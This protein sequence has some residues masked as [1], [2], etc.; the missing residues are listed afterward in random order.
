[1]KIKYWY[2]LLKRIRRGRAVLLAA[3]VTLSIIA[4][5]CATPPNPTASNSTGNPD[6]GPQPEMPAIAATQARS[7][8]TETRTPPP[9]D[10]SISL[11]VSS[12]R[13]VTVVPYLATGYRYL[14]V[15]T[16]QA[17]AGFEQPNFD[18]SAF[19]VGDAAFGSSGDCPIAS[20]VI[21]SWPIRTDI[22]L[23]KKFTLPSGATGLK[24]AVAIDNDIQVFVN[25]V[26]ISGGL[27]I[28][29][30]C[31][32]N[33]SF[34]FSAPDSVLN[35][36]ENLVAVLGRDRGIES[37]L[38]IQV[39]AVIPV[40]TITTT[41]DPSSGEI[42]V[43]LNDSATLSDG[44][45]PT[46]TITFNLYRPSD[47]TCSGTPAF[48]N[49]VPVNGNGTYPTS[50]G[51]L[52]NAVGIWH[53]TATYSGDNNNDPASSLCADEPVT[54]NPATPFITT[55]PDPSSGMI[56]EI[57][58]DSATL[59]DGFNPTGDITFN[60]YAPSDPTCSG[61]PVFT[62]VVPVNGNGTY[63]T[64][65]GF[66]SNAVGVWQWTADYSGDSNNDPASS[67]CADEP[68][69][70]KKAIP[71]IA[72]T[73]DPSSG[74][75]GVTLNDSADLSR[76]F[77]PTGTITFNLYPPNDPTCSGV[78][79]FTDVVP[80]DGEGTYPTSSGFVS[81][82]VGVWHWT[83]TYSGDS[84]NDA[85]SSDCGDEPVTISPGPPIKVTG[86]GQ[87][88]VPEPT[89]NGQAT[90]GFNAQQNEAGSTAATGHFNYVNHDTGLHVNGPVNEIQVIA[91]YPDGSPKT[92]QFSGTCDGN[93]PACTFIV[94]VEDH[95]EPG[96][97]DEFG[98]TVTG[99]L[100]ESQSQRVI[101]QGN[102]QF[103][104]R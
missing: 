66:P 102:I 77:N 5:A 83:A 78:P 1:M 51:F 75:I 4:A 55:T 53:W 76:G 47:P 6:T 37:Y 20:N 27:R 14:V 17:P 74:T 15:G 86:G 48:T 60:L 91:V 45:N 41:P 65:S 21:T 62:D 40:P 23:R 68:V 16:G 42:G 98:I 8:P 34:V 3:T 89:S 28:H 10:T 58:N 24:V 81:N 9:A 38:D 87:I 35:S 33:D 2:A 84:N 59:S 11:L 19:P 97:D 50:S 85:A 70:I 71:R 93:L 49:V 92:V 52:S 12:G 22:V 18:D 101:S 73:P 80:V 94:T 46:G 88:P 64:S 72:T 32:S 95:G 56:G 79:A 96:T 100:T 61:T 39:T 54:V 67:P 69:E 82:A 25:G 36:G 104:I 13:T 44:F 90:F 99:E 7:T 43:I 103:H 31:T 63:P 26:D 30:N 57:L 29:E